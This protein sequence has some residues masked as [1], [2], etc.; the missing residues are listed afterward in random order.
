MIDGRAE[1]LRTPLYDLHVAAGARLVPFG[2]WSMPL[3]Y[4]GIIAEHQAVRGAVG[5]F[6]L[7]HMGRLYFRGQPGRAL[8]Q[9]ITTNDVEALAPGRAQYSLICAEDGGILDDTVAY[10]LGDE[11]L[12]VVNASNRLKVLTWLGR[13]AAAANLAATVDDLTGETAMLGLQGPLAEAVLQPLTALDL[14]ALRFYAATSGSVAGLTALVA[15]TGY[16]GE[17]GFEL[18][19]RAADGP[20]LWQALA[21]RRDPAQPVACGLGA[22]DTLRLEA[23]MALYGHE[24]DEATNPFEAGLG[25]VVKLEKGPFAGRAALQA[26]SRREPDRRLVGFQMVGRAV[27]R[28][29]YPILVSGA[30]V[31]KVTSGSFSPTLGKG[32]GLAYVQASAAEPG[33][34]VE[35]LIRERSEPARVVA[36]PHY[37]HRRRPGSPKPQAP[38]A[39]RSS[40][41][42]RSR[43]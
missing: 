29:G 36:L 5:L 35:V 10:N 34:L 33:R 30:Q 11:H 22:R 42:L 23:G 40:H 7:S 15:R 21:A 2:G 12:L 28:Q 26:L 6:D 17:D 19:V 31:G 43:E 37:Q 4:S 18:V 3:Q 27:P 16:T 25:R 13:Q 39:P 8:L 14:S 24:L 32:L 38:P 20:D 1:L 41:S 9:H